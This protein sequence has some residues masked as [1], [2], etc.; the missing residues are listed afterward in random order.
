MDSV[1]FGSPRGTFSLENIRCYSCTNAYT[2]FSF[3]TDSFEMQ[4]GL[5]SNINNDDTISKDN[6]TLF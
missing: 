1:E 4:N 2:L 5:V 6:P 3:I